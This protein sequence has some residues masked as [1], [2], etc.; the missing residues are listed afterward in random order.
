[1]DIQEIF[2]SFFVWNSRNDA[3]TDGLTNQVTMV[4]C[5]SACIPS[6]RKT[7]SIFGIEHA[8]RDDSFIG[9]RIRFP[10]SESV[11]SDS[12]SVFS[13]SA[14]PQKKSKHEFRMY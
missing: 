11:F 4:F 2:L 13:D 3:L 14:Y 6:F 5:I 1:M 9:F 7:Y 12:A 8:S 10:G